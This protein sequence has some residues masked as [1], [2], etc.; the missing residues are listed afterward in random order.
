MRNREEEG[1]PAWAI[2]ASPLLGSPRWI[3]QFYILHPR[4]PKHGRSEPGWGRVCVCCGGGWSGTAIGTKASP[5]MMR[6]ECL[7]G[8]VQEMARG[9][10]WGHARSR[11]GWAGGIRI[12]GKDEELPG[13]G[14]PTLPPCFVVRVRAEGWGG[15]LRGM[16]HLPGMGM[17]LAACGTLWSQIAILWSASPFQFF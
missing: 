1:E 10:S 4:S 16:R 9:E 12:Q 5:G 8:Q 14:K 17:L 6:E 7:A 11:V 2:P 3:G 15:I 13:L